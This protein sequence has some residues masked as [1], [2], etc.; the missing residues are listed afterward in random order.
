MRFDLRSFAQATNRRKR[1]FLYQPKKQIDMQLLQQIANIPKNQIA[2]SV[3]TGIEQGW[4]ESEII[5]MLKSMAYDNEDLFIREFGE[6][7]TNKIKNAKI[8]MAD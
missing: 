7:I 4:P 5:K 1:L 6:K 2:I 8:T 3:K